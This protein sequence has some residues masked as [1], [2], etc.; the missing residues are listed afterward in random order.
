MNQ[1]ISF[2]SFLGLYINLT[3]SMDFSPSYY[4]SG[5]SLKCDIK[6]NRSH[7]NVAGFHV[8]K[9][10]L[11]P[12]SSSKVI[13]TLLLTFICNKPMENYSNLDCNIA[14]HVFFYQLFQLLCSRFNISFAAFRRFSLLY[15]LISV[16]IFFSVSCS[17]N[18]ESQSTHA[19]PGGWEIL[20]GEKDLEQCILSSKI[21]I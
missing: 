12:K 2:S 4:A 3:H 15:P 1:Y 11:K 10:R 17:P 13:G 5:S 20:S 7:I 21:K 8:P 9:L 6:S 18:L 19:T 16:T 14:Q